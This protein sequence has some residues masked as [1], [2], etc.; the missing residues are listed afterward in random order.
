MSDNNGHEKSAEELRAEKVA[1]FN[2]NPDRFVSMDELVIAIRKGNK[3]METWLGPFTR[4]DFEVALSRITYNVHKVFQ[5]MDAKA[6]MDNGSKLVV[7]GGMHM[8][9]KEF[10]KRRN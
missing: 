7:P 9:P 6:A 2:E 5:A 1:A 3:G 10:A 4:V 8:S